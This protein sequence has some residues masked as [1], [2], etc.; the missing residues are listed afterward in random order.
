MSKL[1]Y[2]GDCEIEFKVRHDADHAFFPILYCPF[3]GA[4]LDISEDPI[5][6]EEEE[7]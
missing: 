6:P 1:N 2:C 4:S 3:C 7:E 5:F